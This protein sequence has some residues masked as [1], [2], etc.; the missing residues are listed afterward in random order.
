[1]LL[2]NISRSAF[3]A[4]IISVL[5]FSCQPLD[6]DPLPAYLSEADMEGMI[7]LG[8]KLENPYTVENMQ[9][10]WENLKAAGR[11]DTDIDITTSHLYLKF[12]PKTEEELDILKSDSTLILYDYPL[13]VEIEGEGDFYHDPSI[14]IDQ[15]TYQYVGVTVDQVL[16]DGV[17]YEVLAE[18]FVPDEYKDGKANRVAGNLS[19]ATVEALVNEALRITG[20]LEEGDNPE[21]GDNARITS[22]SWRPA[23]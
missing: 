10:A 1:M 13:D 3:M 7:K 17:E 6:V 18:L 23:G 2:K 11:V 5:V 21:E 14:P 19:E 12:M 8:K 16:P 20:N 15:P 9:K 22:S 4:V